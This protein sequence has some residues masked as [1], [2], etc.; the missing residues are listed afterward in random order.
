MAQVVKCLYSKS[1]ALSSNPS[2]EKNKTKW[3]KIK[4]TSGCHSGSLIDVHLLEVGTSYPFQVV[5]I[6]V[7]HVISGFVQILYLSLNVCT[8]DYTP[9]LPL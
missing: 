2:T 5:G 1:K 7:Y 4:N 9:F 8:I 3:E 6:F